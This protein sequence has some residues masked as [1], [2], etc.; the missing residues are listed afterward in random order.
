[1]SALRIL[2]IQFKYLGDA[3]FIT[4]ALR[5]LKEHQPDA[6]IHVLVASEVA[7]L[8]AHLSWIKK[9]WPLPRTR[10]SARLRDSWPLIRALRREVF[11]RAVDFGGND[12]GAI[13]SFFSGAKIRLAPDHHRLLAK[14]CYTQRIPVETL[15]ASWVQRHL[16]LLAAWQVPPPRSDRP[17]IAADPALEKSVAAPFPRGTILC[18]VATSN[19]RKQWPPAHW[20]V[21]YQLAVAAGLPLM[22]STGHSQREQDF[23]VR[24]K[25]IVPQAPMLPVSQNLDLFLVWLK[26]AAV[27]ISGDTGPL[28]FAAALGVPIIGL[29]GT[30]DSLSRSAPIYTPE[31][32]ITATDCACD[33]LN[34]NISTCD[35]PQPCMATIAPAQVLT[36]LQKILATIR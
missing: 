24:I 20:A 4:P 26:Q 17:E 12:R 10:G 2:A 30:G 1:V 31:Q 25:A 33:R 14:I 27:F 8:L 34:K 7:P 32:I 9:M 19:D 6:E 23:L 35:E 16:Q 5:A 22:F 36:R 21:F 18:H 15:P 29:F 13:L 11:D 28:H 3:V